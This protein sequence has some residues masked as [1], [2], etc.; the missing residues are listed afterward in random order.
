MECSICLDML[1][2]DKLWLTCNHVFHNT[3][4]TRWKNQSDTCPVC[5]CTITSFYKPLLKSMIQ[6]CYET[7]YPMK[8]NVSKL[9]YLTFEAST[10]YDY[11]HKI[12]LYYVT[13]KVLENSDVYDAEFLS[14]FRD[15]LHMFIE[16]LPLIINIDDTCSEKLLLKMKKRIH[17][18]QLI[19]E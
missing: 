19:N 1:T 12:S 3:C 4:I 6:S 7:I 16:L 17:K 8:N 10:S 14:L 9:L 15:K 5:R 11:I 2:T 13:M 18:F